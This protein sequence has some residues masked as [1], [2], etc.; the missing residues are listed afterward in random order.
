[1]IEYPDSW[2]DETCFIIGG[3]SVYHQAINAPFLTGIYL[4]RI[5][6]QF[7]CDTFFPDI[8]DKFSRITPLGEVE[9]E[10][11]SYEYLLYEREKV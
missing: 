11:V 5:K 2:K 8:P 1:M 3:G 7:N 6:K 10:D 9:E 4:T